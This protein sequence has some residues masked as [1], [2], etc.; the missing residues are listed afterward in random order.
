MLSVD[1]V[2]AQR[3]QRLHVGTHITPPA[4]TVRQTG[5]RTMPRT[6]SRAVVLQE[7]ISGRRPEDNI[8]VIASE[9]IFA[10]NESGQVSLRQFRSE[11]PGRRRG[12]ISVQA[13]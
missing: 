9:E 12:T 8:S 7:L 4:R 1:K 11:E 3:E 13:R 5:R 6:Q 10:A 2:Q